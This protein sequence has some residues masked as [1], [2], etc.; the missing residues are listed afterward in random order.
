ME[1][2]LAN[3]IAKV[4]D[5]KTFFR[6]AYLDRFGKDTDVSTDVAAYT[7]IGKIPPYVELYVTKM[8][9][10]GGELVLAARN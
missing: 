8:Q 6:A 9:Q 10:K 5:V 3:A 1:L 4:G 7:K 2:Y